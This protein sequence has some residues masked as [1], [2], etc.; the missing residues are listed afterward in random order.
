MVAGTYNPGQPSVEADDY[1]RADFMPSSGTAASAS[2]SAFLVRMRRTNN[3]NGLDQEPGISSGGPTLP[4]LFGRGSLMARSAALSGGTGQLSVASG[5]TVRATAIAGPQPAKTVGPLYTT[6]GTLT[7]VRPACALCD[8]RAPSGRRCYPTAPRTATAVTVPDPRVQLLQP[9]FSA[10]L[11]A[12]GQPLVDYDRCQRLDR[13]FA[14]RRCTCR[15]MP[16]SPA[17]RGRSL[18][19]F[20]VTWSY[21]GASLT[22]GPATAAV[23]IGGQNVSP[24]M[25]L[26]LPAA[27]VP[28]DVSALFQDHANLFNQYPLYAPA[29]VNR[30]IG[31]NTP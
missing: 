18:V 12:I 29:L 1:T 17:K 3:L 26:P 10:S 11:T 13:R 4:I 5:I 6:G 15:S 23:Q 30:Y 24:T 9:A 19:S 22:L 8:H 28:A 31:P 21:T 20:T 25:A 16:I 2:G 14:K 7:A 27:L